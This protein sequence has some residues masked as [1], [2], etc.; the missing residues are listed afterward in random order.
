M[1]RVNLSS[2]HIPTFAS[3]QTSLPRP[4]KKLFFRHARPTACVYNVPAASGGPFDH[5]F[6]EK[7]IKSADRKRLLRRDSGRRRRVGSYTKYVRV[8]FVFRIRHYVS[9]CYGRGFPSIAFVSRTRVYSQNHRKTR[10]PK[11][12][13]CFLKQQFFKK[14]VF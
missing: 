3:R 11:R 9:C 5:R 1:S 12:L 10:K 6:R 7:V 4:E 13:P 2:V 8:S 14:K